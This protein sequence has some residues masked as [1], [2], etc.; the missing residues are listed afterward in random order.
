MKWV[1]PQLPPA[2]STAELT[3]KLPFPNQWKPP[4]TSFFKLPGAWSANSRFRMPLLFSFNTQM[5]LQQWARRGE[6]AC[7]QTQRGH[8]P[9]LQSELG[10]VRQRRLCSESLGFG[11]ET[12][13]PLSLEATKGV[14]EKPSFNTKPKICAC[15]FVF[16]WHSSM[17]VILSF[18]RCLH[19]KEDP[20]PWNGSQLLIFRS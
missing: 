20:W 6:M 4:S 1:N 18:C 16:I 15:H 2:E 10:W 19:F 12:L 13:R 9:C 5:L 7:F 14:V 8:Q 3:I 11:S 17:V